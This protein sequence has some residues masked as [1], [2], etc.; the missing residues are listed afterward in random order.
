MPHGRE[1]EPDPRRQE[2]PRLPGARD[3]LPGPAFGGGAGGRHAKAGAACFRVDSEGVLRVLL[4]T[5]TIGQWIIPKG[6]VEKHQSPQAAALQEAWE[7]AGVHGWVMGTSLGP[8][9]YE[10]PTVSG[11]VDHV[12]VLPVWVDELAR[13][14]P[15]DHKRQRRWATIREAM[16]LIDD[17]SLRRVLVTLARRA[18]AGHL[19][20]A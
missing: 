5:S 9:Q 1:H 16:E 19:R 6:T 10:H 11:R 3:G 14:W 2:A 20:A 12:E 7:E 13:T 17:Q 8:W 4:I 18:S 15:E